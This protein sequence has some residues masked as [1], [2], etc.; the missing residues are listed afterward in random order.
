VTKHFVEWSFR[1][2]FRFE[3]EHLLE[4]SGFEIEAV[5]GDYGESPFTST[6]DVLLLLGRR[7]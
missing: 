2:T 4:R 1:Y 7:R 3:A 5:Y 6:S